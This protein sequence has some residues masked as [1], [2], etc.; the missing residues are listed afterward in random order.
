MADLPRS[1]AELQLWRTCS[2]DIPA[3]IA[4][5]SIG[6]APHACTSEV[7]CGRT[8]GPGEA[9]RRAHGRG[10]AVGNAFA[11]RGALRCS[12]CWPHKSTTNLVTTQKHLK[13]GCGSTGRQ[14]G[15]FG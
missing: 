13:R 15:R 4:L 1:A 3:S 14:C 6:M 2:F 11:A 12:Y 5:A 8:C 7:S 9:R 10:P